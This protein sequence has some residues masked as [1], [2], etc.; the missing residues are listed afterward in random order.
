MEGGC[1]PNLCH[2]S[3]CLQTLS[4]FAPWGLPCKR[5]KYS[6]P[7][8]HNE[9]AI[10]QAQ[11]YPEGTWASR[12]ERESR[13]RRSPSRTQVS[14][15]VTTSSGREE[16]SPASMTCMARTV[17]ESTANIRSALLSFGDHHAPDQKE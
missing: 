17:I 8:R 4:H 11:G 16:M 12:W 7:P 2:Q 5:A 13:H 1:C 9:L 3:H 15:G 6:R 14:A 10:G